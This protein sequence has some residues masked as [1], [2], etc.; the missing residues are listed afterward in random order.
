LH[1]LVSKPSPDELARDWVALN[2]IGTFT[3]FVGPIYRRMTAP[4]AQ[5]PFRIGFEVASH[6]C[7]PSGVCHGGMLSCAMDIALGRGAMVALGCPGSTPTIT[8]T[9]DFMAVARPGEWIESRAQ[10]IHSTHRT[11][12]MHCILHGPSGVVA[13]GSGVFKMSVPKP[14]KGL[15]A[16]GKSSDGSPAII[17]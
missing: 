9:I 6:H 5:E 3:A 11:S 7:N 16:A 12:F 8:M 2:D 10:L 4:S 17:N 13:R 14:S 1:I 15:L